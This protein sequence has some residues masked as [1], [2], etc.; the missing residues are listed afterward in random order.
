MLVINC[1]KCG[2]QI[3]MQST[4]LSVVCPHCGTEQIPPKMKAQIEADRLAHLERKRR[5]QQIIDEKKARDKRLAVR[6]TVPSAITVVVIILAIVFSSELSLAM[7]YSRAQ[8]YMRQGEYQQAY[9]IFNSLSDYKDSIEHTKNLR[10]IF[11]KLKINDAKVGSTVNF[12]VYEQDNDITNG[13]EEL[14]WVVLEKKENKLLLLCN[15]LTVPRRYNDTYTSVFWHRCDAREWLNSDFIDTV[16]STEQ[17]EMLCTTQV[18]TS[19][20]PVHNT[21][22]GNDTE[23]K[24]FLLSEDEFFKYCVPNGIAWA[25]VTLYAA[26]QGAYRDLTVNT[27]LWWLRTPGISQGRAAFV[28]AS[29]NIQYYGEICEAEIY[30]LRPAMWVDVG[31][32][33][34]DLSDT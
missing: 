2:E 9:E 23:D 11:Q 16:F 5:T 4:D 17:Q 14:E 34:D 28:D 7:K 27:G 13:P 31:I 22:G 25:Y 33:V 15:M 8:R 12:G 1:E 30:C 26:A 18:H 3:Q 24:L 32:D 29:G 20:N 21:H 6:I 10:V 19:K